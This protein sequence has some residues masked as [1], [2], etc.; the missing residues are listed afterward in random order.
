MSPGQVWIALASR[1]L[2]A[3][4]AAA[5]LVG[6][7]RRLYLGFRDGPAYVLAF[8]PLPL[9]VATPYGGEIVF[10]VYLFALP[11][12]AF[13][14]GG[15]FFPTR[16]AGRTATTKCLASGFGL[17]LAVGFLLANNG[18]DRQYRFTAEEIAAAAWLY[19]RAPAGS[20]LI[21][22]S[23][24]YPAQFMNYEKFTYLPLSR[25]S[26]EAQREILKDPVNVLASWLGDRKW[27]AGFVIITTSQKAS[28]DSLGG[29]PTGS[30][31]EIE[32]ALLASP[33]FKLVH[34]TADA[35]IFTLHPVAARMGAWVQ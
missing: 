11:F 29:M 2:T 35:T 6:G 13:F 30:L 19:E 18:K 9:L 12:L 34:A 32:R 17:L 25:E 20:L 4:V 16:T 1:T 5:A 24:N 33:K 10:R 27:E 26:P 28:V 7:I 15:L 8:A 3:T 31:D 14:A 23:R 22:G 21:E